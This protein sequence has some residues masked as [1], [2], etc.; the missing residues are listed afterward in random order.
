MNMGERCDVGSWEDLEVE[1]R[2]ANMIRIY[3][4]YV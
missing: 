1:I 4:K 3:C 2:R